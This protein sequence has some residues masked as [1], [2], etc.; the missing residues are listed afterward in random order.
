MIPREILFGNPEKNEPRISPDGTR[1]AFTAPYRGVLNVW[2]KT[3]GKEDDHPITFDE[4]R[5]IRSF[6][7]A[8]NNRQIAYIQDKNG[9]E[10]WH[11][12]VISTDN[13]NPID[14]TPIDGIQARVIAVNPKHPDTILISINDR[15]PQLHDVYKVN[16]NTAERSLVQLNDIG[17]Y[18]WLADHDLNI[19]LGQ[20]PAPDGGF[21]LKHKRNPSD[22]WKTLFKWSSEDAF[23]T[24]LLTFAQDNC[25]LYMTSSIGSNSAQM[26]TYNVETG[27]ETVISSDDIYDVSEYLFHPVTHHLQAVAFNR[28]RLVWQVLDPSIREDLNVISNL[29]RGDFHIL[30]RDD[31]DQTWL[32]AF[33]RDIGA[34]VYY[35]YHRTEK[36]GSFLFASRPRLYDYRLSET[37]PISFTSRDGLEIHGYLTIP[38][39]CKPE[40]LPSILHI[41][42]GPWNRVTW[43]FDQVIQFLADRGYAVLQ[44]N[45]RGSTGYGKVFTNAGDKEWGGKMQNDITDAAHWMIDEGI[46]D[47]ERIG[48]Y[49]SSFGGFAVLSALT[50]TPQLFRCGVDI[51]GPSDLLSF[52]KSIPSYWEPVKPLLHRRIGHPVHD[53]IMLQERSPLNNIDKIVSPLMIIQGVNDARVKPAES[54]QI[55]DA[56]LKTGKTVQYLEFDN[57]GHGIVRPESRMLFF[58][59]VE[60]FLASHLN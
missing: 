32:V 57:E 37:N 18:E 10:N 43:G 14:L 25:T 40:N 6:F 52:Q 27:L 24:R 59:E 28:D 36:K 8:K 3:V 19:R 55:R 34:P 9:D 16:L 11:L 56:L 15:V 54:L 13:G 22:E 7:W 33:T 42:G 38:D 2:V 44:M 26:R 53:R 23:G 58:K 20:V 50:K 12:W 1:L 49:G 17:A 48:I 47:P 41:H 35:A 21:I 60:R 46:A 51:F 5:G 4:G 39:G 30:R 45:F 29:Q 31:L